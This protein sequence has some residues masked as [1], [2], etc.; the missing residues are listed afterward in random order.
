MP[1]GVTPTTESATLEP[2]DMAAKMG[3]I[4]ATVK[5]LSNVA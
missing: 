2:L 5:A 3:R 4:A 1:K